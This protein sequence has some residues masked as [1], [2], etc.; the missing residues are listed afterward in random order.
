MNSSSESKPRYHSATVDCRP[1][2]FT[3]RM[4]TSAPR[5]V[6]S[7]V[8][9]STGRPVRGSTVSVAPRTSLLWKP[10]PQLT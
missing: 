4:P 2:I 8:S 9:V 1:R 5:A 6:T 7:G 3:V 10:W